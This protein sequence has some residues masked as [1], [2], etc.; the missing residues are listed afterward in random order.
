[1]ANHMGRCD[2]GKISGW[3]VLLGWIISEF[4][5]ENGPGKPVRR[6]R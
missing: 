2:M 3:R 4:S 6:K 1:M 5:A